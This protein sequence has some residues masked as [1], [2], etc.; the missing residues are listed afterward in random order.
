VYFEDLY[1]GCALV[2]E[3]DAYLG[4]RGFKRTLTEDAYYLGEFKGFGDALY[5][6]Q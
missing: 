3:L 4:D 6:R 1:E 2:E 5:T